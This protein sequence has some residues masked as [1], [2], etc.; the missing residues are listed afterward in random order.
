M[1]RAAVA[2][3]VC[4]TWCVRSWSSYRRDEGFLTSF[5]R[6][7]Q[8][9]SYIPHSEALSLP[10]SR[11][12]Q[13]DSPSSFPSICLFNIFF[14]VILPYCSFH[15]HFLGL[16]FLSFIYSVRCVGAC[17][18]HSTLVLFILSSKHSNTSSSRT[19]PSFSQCF[20]LPLSFIK[21]ARKSQKNHHLQSI[22]MC[23]TCVCMQGLTQTLLPHF[24]VP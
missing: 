13:H 6:H 12:P 8:H 4:R 2:L 19:R 10:S 23:G 22:M 14:P 5:S 11:T 21:P 3:W 15:S 1:H 24:R 20:S 18:T 16:P 17:L 7:I 9:I